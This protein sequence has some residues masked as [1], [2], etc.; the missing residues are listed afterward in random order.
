[1]ISKEVKKE[2]LKRAKLNSMKPVIGDV[3]VYKLEY[4]N[5]IFI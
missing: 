2:V 4:D 3:K 1:M 5:I